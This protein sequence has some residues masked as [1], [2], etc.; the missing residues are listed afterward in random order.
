MSPLTT[1]GHH[2]VE[3]AMHDAVVVQKLN[4]TKYTK[5]FPLKSPLA[6]NPLGASV[7]GRSN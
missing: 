4:Q 5:P 3:L 2:V 1:D 7:Q 6:K